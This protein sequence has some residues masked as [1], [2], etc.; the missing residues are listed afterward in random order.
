MAPIRG[1]S[2]R[3]RSGPGGGTL[4][5]TLID[6]YRCRRRLNMDPLASDE[7]R[8]PQGAP[9]DDNREHRLDKAVR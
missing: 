8:T 3:H 4:V 2:P 1:R 5:V 9:A 6:W 7:S